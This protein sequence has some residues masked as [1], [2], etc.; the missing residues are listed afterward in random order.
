M[1]WIFREHR[2][3]L[4][5]SMNT[6][7]E[8]KT[9]KEMLQYIYDIHK[10]YGEGIGDNQAPFEI[11]DIVIQKEEVV[12]DSR[13]GW[14]TMHV[15]V[16]KYGNEDYMKKYGSPQCIGQCS[17]DYI[18]ATLPEINMGDKILCLECRNVIE[19]TRDTFTIDES[20]E[21]IICPTCNCKHDVQMYHRLGTK[22]IRYGL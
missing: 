8:F 5:E 14:H 2:G 10:K 6:A 15:C 18:H 16:K 21:Y 1:S 22:V 13:T 7:R 3:G 11:E 9:E 20:A 4:I 12:Y 19:I 17:N